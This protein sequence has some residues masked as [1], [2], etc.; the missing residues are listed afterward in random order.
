MSDPQIPRPSTGHEVRII[1][2]YHHPPYLISNTAGRHGRLST[3]RSQSRRLSKSLDWDDFPTSA[4]SPLWQPFLENEENI[5]SNKPGQSIGNGKNNFYFKQPRYP[6]KASVEENVLDLPPKET[7]PT[8]ELIIACDKCLGRTASG[9]KD[10]ID[11]LTSNLV[12][13]DLSNKL[14][15]KETEQPETLLEVLPSST[16]KWQGTQTRPP[17]PSLTFTLPI[18]HLPLPTQQDST[19]HPARVKVTPDPTYYSASLDHGSTIEKETVSGR[20]KSST[21]PTIDSGHIA[22][23]RNAEKRRRF[24]ARK[25]TNSAPDSF[26][27]SSFFNVTTHGVIDTTRT[28]HFH[29][30][31]RSSITPSNIASIIL[32]PTHVSKNF[33][34]FGGFFFFLENTIFESHILFPR[35][36]YELNRFR[37]PSTTL[38]VKTLWTRFCHFQKS[39]KR[40]KVGSYMEGEGEKAKPTEPKPVDPL[41]QDKGRELHS[42]YSLSMFI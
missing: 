12:Q 4:H 9:L 32:P 38:S 34:V 22:A 19:T 11:T 27:A 31:Y 17:R 14:N 2:A 41:N 29:S 33:H 20:G 39:S 21:L 40:N 42:A 37:F 25:Q 36:T 35:I 23:I 10:E 6:Q 7:V 1:H 8:E 28:F 3:F 16:T 24:F 13:T 26:E 30:F 18:S 15:S 5:G